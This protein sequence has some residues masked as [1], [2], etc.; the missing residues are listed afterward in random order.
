M[1]TAI[2]EELNSSERPVAKAIHRSSNG[3]C[4]GIGMKA[5]MEIKEHKAHIP[6]TLLVLYGS[7]RYLEGNDQKVI[8]THDQHAIPVDVL[9]AVEALEDSLILL[10]QV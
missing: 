6:T 2:L 3:K 5:G 9:H 8:S 10:I 4:I 7:I 1:I